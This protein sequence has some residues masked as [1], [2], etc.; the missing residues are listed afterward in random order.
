MKFN[1]G[2]DSALA[3]QRQVTA[4]DIII[5]FHINL[6]VQGTIVTIPEIHG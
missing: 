6:T 5:I 1:S 3:D 4:E 2:D